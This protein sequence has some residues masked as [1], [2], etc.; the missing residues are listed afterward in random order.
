MTAANQLVSIDIGSH[1]IC[2][3][4]ARVL[5]DQRIAID[6]IGI[7]PSHGFQRGTITSKAHLS[8]SIK[9]SLERA[10]SIAGS[11]PSLAICS[12]PQ[13]N[14]HFVKHTGFV[15]KPQ[16]TP[17]TDAEIQQ[18]FQRSTQLPDVDADTT[19][20]HAIPTIVLTK[21]PLK[22]PG[23]FLASPWKLPRTLS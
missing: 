1:K 16:A 17:I 21:Q 4:I 15:H 6:G 22:T 9:Q 20:I 2:T 13:D 12:L 11:L 23:A 14:L 10:K 5:A 19:I 18:C 3:V 8:S 7:S